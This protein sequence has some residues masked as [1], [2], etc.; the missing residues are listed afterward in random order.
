MRVHLQA[1]VPYVTY[2]ILGVT[3]A[4]FL[5]QLAS[6]LLFGYEDGTVPTLFSNEFARALITGSNHVDLLEV[7]GAN[8]NALIRAGQLW[9]LL[10]PILLHGSIPHIGFNMYALY[11]LGIGLEQTY[12]HRRF[13]LLYLLGGFAGNV[14]SFLFLRAGGY[15]VGAST[16]LF[17]LVGAEGIF[18]Y[19]NRAFFGKQY[20]SAIRNILFVVALNVAIGFV[21]GI[22]YWG[23]AGGLLSGLLFAWLA[24]PKWDVHGMEPNLEAEDSRTSRDVVTGA[25]AVLLVFGALTLWG[26]VTH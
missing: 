18:I 25:A 13:L 23:H 10:T 2:T 19:Q 4:V 20:G 8:D 11:I 15:S 12:G 7:F 24:G 17:A 5:L 3:I 6:A 14:L 16:A 9:R 1:G 21:P 26:M 22:D